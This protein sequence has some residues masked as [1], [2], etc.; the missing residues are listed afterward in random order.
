MPGKQLNRAVE[1]LNASISQC[2]QALVMAR[3]ALED[4][5][6]DTLVKHK[7]PLLLASEKRLKFLFIIKY[8]SNE[9]LTRK[10]EPESTVN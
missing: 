10:P 6:N 2:E 9:S 4:L 8:K 5:S 7:Q 1:Q 3:M